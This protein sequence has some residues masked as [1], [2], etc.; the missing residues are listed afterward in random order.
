MQIEWWTWL[1]PG[2]IGLTHGRGNRVLHCQ[3]KS[4]HPTKEASDPSL[5]TTAPS[6]WDG[7]DR[8]SPFGEKP[9][10][11]WVHFADSRSLHKVCTGLPNP[12]QD[13]ERW[14]K[15]FTMILYHDLD[16]HPVYT[17]TKGEN[18]RTISS[19]NCINCLAFPSLAP[20]PTTLKGMGK[21]REWT[22]RYCLLRT[23]SDLKKRK[24]DESLNKMVHAYNC[25]KH[26][27]TGVLA[28]LFDVWT[29]TTPT[30]RPGV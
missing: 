20:A 8:L 15:R 29:N 26:E 12:K 7:V 14:L 16:F 9:T 30:H 1:G 11:I 6:Y 13:D 27:A 3:Q 22:A 19:V 28:V 23:L 25:T 10:G 18:L 2:S 21:L 24:W 17:V 4:L 5:S